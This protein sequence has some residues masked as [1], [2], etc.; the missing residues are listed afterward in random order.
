MTGQLLIKCFNCLNGLFQSSFSKDFYSDGNIVSEC[1]EQDLSGQRVS[2]CILRVHWDETLPSHGIRFSFTWLQ[3]LHPSL[4]WCCAPQ[5][6]ILYFLPRSSLHLPWA[7]I[8]SFGSVSASQQR[9]DSK[10]D[11]WKEHAAPP[12]CHG[13]VTHEQRK[14]GKFM[15]ASQK[16]RYSSGWRRWVLFAE[17]SWQTGR[18]VGNV[19]MQ[20]M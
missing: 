20:F 17:W 8:S 15:N 18:L 5:I 19:F 10:G 14:P 16:K 1:P 4:G 6:S 13:N 12:C 3:S 9:W 2:L 11:I 7:S